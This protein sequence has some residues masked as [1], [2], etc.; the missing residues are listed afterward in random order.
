MRLAKRERFLYSMHK[1][2]SLRLQ[3]SPQELGLDHGGDLLGGQDGHKAMAGRSL[4]RYFVQLLFRPTGMGGHD[5][6]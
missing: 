2:R 5:H 3:T 1:A 4:N 6:G